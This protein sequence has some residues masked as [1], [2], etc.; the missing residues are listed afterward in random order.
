MA[1]ENNEAIIFSD[2]KLRPLA[3]DLAQLYNKARAALD[4]WNARGMGSIIVNAEAPL[5]D[6]AYGTDGTDGD[7]RPVVTGAE[8]TNVVTRLGEFVADMEAGGN[9]KLNTVLAVAVNTL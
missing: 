1:I 6:S 7:G 3:D 4:E 8:L 9:A 5:G 2:E